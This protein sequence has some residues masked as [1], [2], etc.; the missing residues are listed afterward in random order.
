MQVELF[1]HSGCRSA[2]ASYHLVRECM[3]AL[4]IDE[5]VLVRVGLYPSPTMLVNGI[6]V[7]RPTAALSKS[8]ACRI[9]VPTRGRVMAALRAHLAAESRDQETPW[10]P[11][12]GSRSRPVGDGFR[13]G[14]GHGRSA[15]ENSSAATTWCTGTS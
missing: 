13:S 3:T 5:P 10:R 9:D 2:Q 12:R 7:M 4:G 11:G 6:D 1:H 15:S 8:D 14:H